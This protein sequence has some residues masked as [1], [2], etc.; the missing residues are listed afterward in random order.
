MRPL[1][2]LPQ[3]K[4]RAARRAT[5]EG[6]VIFVV[7]MTLAVLAAIG[8]WAMQSAAT[9]VR[10]AGY[11]RQN[12]QTHY[13]SEYGAFAVMQD[14]NSTIGPLFLA[15][16][17]CNPNSCVAAPTGGVSGTPNGMLKAC[18]RL[19]TSSDVTAPV[20]NANVPGANSTTLTT[21]IAPYGGDAGTT[22][23]GSLGAIP[24][25]G[26]FWVEL[27]D[28]TQLAAGA[29]N[30]INNGFNFYQI[31]LTAGGLT[32]QQASNTTALYGSEGVELQRVRVVAG[33]LPART[34]A[35]SK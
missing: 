27:T 21:P 6:G 35:G 31:T 10:T 19:G 32:Q 17:L 4:L 15:Q 14:V 5:E 9:E 8:A 13:L 25:R 29:G 1:P 11:E 23:P 34:C 33:P 16:A 20:L 22:T 18:I 2:S 7:A 24:M 30:D 12:S 26:D 3:A 28:F